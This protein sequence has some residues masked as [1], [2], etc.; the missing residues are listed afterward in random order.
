MDTRRAFMQNAVLGAAVVA[1]PDLRSGAS[2][3]LRPQVVPRTF[4]SRLD[5][6]NARVA[7]RPFYAGQFTGLDE[8]G[9]ITM[10]TE[11]GS[12]ET[13]SV[14]SNSSIWM[15]GGSG[16]ARGISRGDK[17]YLTADATQG[18][19][20][21]AEKV[22]VN[23]GWV[24]GTVLAVRGSSVTVQTKHAGVLTALLTP[25]TEVP[26]GLPKV[27]EWAEFLG[28]KNPKTGNVVSTKVFA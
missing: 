12:T 28:F 1:V 21:V 11:R 8:A 23:L 26:G 4:Q 6:Q 24:K 2:R 13:V 22:W 3:R 10:K 17:V 16:A 18:G 5:R 20:P 14:R 7:K 15:N 27:G 9:N 19:R 25:K